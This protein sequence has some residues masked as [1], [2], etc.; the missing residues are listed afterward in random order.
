MQND[1]PVQ[2]NPTGSLILQGLR[3]V[4]GADELKSVHSQAQ[5]LP[6]AWQGDEPSWQGELARSSLAHLQSALEKAYGERCGQG[7]VFRTGQ[8]FF[9][10]LVHN[11]GEAMGL[12]NL[13]FRLLSL[14]KRLR[15]GLEMLAGE[16]RGDLKSPIRIQETGEGWGWQ[17]EKCPWCGG[18]KE[19]HG[20]C[21][22]TSGLL[23]EYF[24]WAS[25]GRFYQVTE[26]D[27][28]ASGG[29]ACSVQVVKKP[30]E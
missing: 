13:E 3:E 26:V 20:I 16:V 2:S 9:H 23:K 21:Q 4:I 19:D 10:S 7:I 12:Y 6:I 28:L 24:S 5:D 17:V 27:C 25:G 18:R 15:A 22:F 29:K 14:R 8:A 1:L 30:L 11:R